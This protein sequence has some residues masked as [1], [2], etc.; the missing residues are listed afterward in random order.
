MKIIADLNEKQE[1][2]LKHIKVVSYI[3]DMEASN[4]PSQIALALDWLQ[5]IIDNTSKDEF[6]NL[7]TKS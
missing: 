4:K 3:V 5:N 7:I 6:L 2:T 1:A